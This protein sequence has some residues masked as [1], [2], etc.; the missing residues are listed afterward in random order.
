LLLAGLW[1][2]LQPADA[3]LVGSALA[4]E[5]T[6]VVESAGDGKSAII[7][8]L[9]EDMDPAERDRIIGEV[10][11]GG[12]PGAAPAA[13]SA[14]DADITGR[15][16][17]LWA[18]LERLDSFVRERSV[19]LPE[20]PTVVTSILAQLSPDNSVA[21]GL[22]AALIGI[23]ILFG[24]GAL[25]ELI[26]RRL[27]WRSV[28]GSGYEASADLTARLQVS[29]SWLLHEF[30]A[31]AVFAAAAVIAFTAVHVAN[32]TTRAVA[33]TYLGAV[34]IIRVIAL[35]SR[36][37]VSPTQPERRMVPLGDADAKAV[38]RRVMMVAVYACL[39]FPTETLAGRLGAPIDLLVSYGMYMGFILVVLQIVVV[40][41]LR[42]PVAQAILGGAG[43]ELAV[44]RLRR[45]VA[46]NWHLY[47]TVFFVA[48]YLIALF[49]R[50]QGVTKSL[51]PAAL[52]TMLLVVLLPM[53]AAASRQLLSEHFERRH[54]AAADEPP[55][56]LRR[57]FEAALLRVI[58]I[59]WLLAAV[60][61]VAVIW[62]VDVFALRATGLG[63]L[64]MDSVLDI[65]AILVIA[66]FLWE[67]VKAAIDQRLR[68]EDPEIEGEHSG[69]VGGMG[70]TRLSTLLPLIRTAFLSVIVIVVVLVALSSI[71]IN[72][73]PLI[74]GAGVI[75]L[76]IG[77][78]AQALVTDIISGI[79]YLID[80]AF[81]RG[82]YINV[83]AVQG[84]VEKISLRSLQLRHQNGPL[85]NVPFGKISTLTNYS[86]DWAIVKF[87]IRVP[88]ETDINQV[89][90]IIKT[91]GKEM[92][93]DETLGQNMLAPLKS[94]GVNRI[95]D[96]A[97]IVRCKFT[98]FPGQQFLIR[99][100]A[101]TRIHEAFAEAGIK[102][103]PRRVV[104]EAQTP[105][106]AV[107]AAAAVEDEAQSKSKRGR[108]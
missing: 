65:G 1:L 64:V 95:D 47:L 68:E 99:R 35:L 53:V 57:G 79:F 74:A 8:V 22:V 29:C 51:A 32:E 31:L 15:G 72:I 14:E 61:F 80:D 58:S 87:E 36:F 24:A 9:P 63:A 43:R 12:E 45:A 52:G 44:G 66:Y 19:L 85:H 56:P 17:K 100:E 34:L 27:I 18:D 98:A 4:Q 69:E 21:G 37:M 70:T 84:T 25:T 96:S 94:Q 10:L 40:W 97:L 88:Y 91:I 5:A 92:M 7:L 107:A 23:V 71:G 76:A 49:M 62:E 42:Q 11:R 89:R 46:G 26:F 60:I 81:R 102:F 54:A 50:A 59:L 73:G 103:A 28:K 90:K 33:N 2:L 101:Y 83:G 38:H 16:T 105:E 77:F 67:L 55:R 108:A 3:G 41:Q 6:Q 106:L 39:V 104:V 20:V 75:G 30:V 48:I 86:R 13:G 82:E 78:G 93:A